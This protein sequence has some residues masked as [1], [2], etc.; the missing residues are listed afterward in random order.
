MNLSERSHEL[1]FETSCRSLALDY[2]VYTQPD[3]TLALST[4]SPK[5]TSVASRDS[6]DRLSS[7]DLAK[8]L[9]FTLSISLFILTPLS[10]ARCRRKLFSTFSFRRIDS[11]Q[12]KS[13]SK[14]NPFTPRVPLRLSLPW[15]NRENVSLYFVHS[16][17]FS[18]KMTQAR[19]I[20]VRALDSAGRSLLDNQ[21]DSIVVAPSTD[22]VSLRSD[23]PTSQVTLDDFAPRYSHQVAQYSVLNAGNNLEILPSGGK[24]VGSQS[25]RTFLISG[26]A[27]DVPPT[28]HTHPQSPVPPSYRSRPGVSLLASSF[29][30]SD[31]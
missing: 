2:I 10:F 25:L 19:T 9:G 7:G 14:V 12:I 11:L 30:H 18:P 13:A 8:I 29:Y 5:P 24:S 20:T 28:Y 4:E 3:T 6:S 15:S 23:R 16:L 22:N 17:L 27:S 26:A 21:A 1:H 31:A